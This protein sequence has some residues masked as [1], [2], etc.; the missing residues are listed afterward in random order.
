VHCQP[1][2]AL[3][4]LDRLMP[5]RE[6]LEGE[7][8]IL[9]YHQ[10][11]DKWVY[12]SKPKTVANAADQHATWDGKYPLCRGLEQSPINIKTEDAVA[13]PALDRALEPR[14]L[15]HVPLLV[16][17]GV[18]FELDLT[19]PVHYARPTSA[20]KVV[21]D[22]AS[23]GTSRIEGG[24][25]NFYQVHWH[26]PSENTVDGVQYPLEAHYVHQLN[27]SSL[28]GTNNRLA[29]V[30][31]LY[32]E[33]ATCNADL[34]AFW[35]ALPMEP[36][37]AAYAQPVDLQAMLAPLLP[38]GYF[39]WSG[40]L[41]T[42]PCTEGVVWNLMKRRS[43]VCPRQLER[44][45]QSVAVMRG[46]VD[47]NNRVVQP[48]NERTIRMTTTATANAALSEELAATESHSGSR[49]LMLGGFGVLVALLAGAAWRPDRSAASASAGSRPYFECV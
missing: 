22:K 47:I 38:A 35:D 33:S 26:T 17:T 15:T 40:S 4:Q 45:K 10:G 19:T 46:G 14:L 6:L 11:T 7:P 8:N 44:L 21:A 39:S 1:R 25:Y 34:D 36:G 32:E 3:L 5:R 41:T 42:P 23:K 18:Y 49:L 31:V 24:T 30:A 27:D 37:S 16:N 2:S 13:T 28:V 12:S 29:V 9:S 48:V 43:K 20:D